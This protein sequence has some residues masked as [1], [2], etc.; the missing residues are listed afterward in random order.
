MPGWPAAPLSSRSIPNG[1]AQQALRA[2]LIVTIEEHTIYG[3]LGDAAAAVLAG[4][5]GHRARLVP[6]GVPEGV[7]MGMAGDQKELPARAGL[8]P[9]A[10]AQGI[11]GVL[12]QE[13]RHDDPQADLDCYA[14]L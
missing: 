14:M 10:I 13:H 12:Q 3:G 2:Q 1:Y 9:E 6:F 7:L 5:T 11:L 8:A 4:M